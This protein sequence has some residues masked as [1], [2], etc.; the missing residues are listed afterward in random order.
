M[1]AIKVDRRLVR[2][3][4]RAKNDTGSIS[5]TNLEDRKYAK[6]TAV[7]VYLPSHDQTYPWLY[8]P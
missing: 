4:F 5:K 8:I 3:R 6:L 2:I 1:T 7:L